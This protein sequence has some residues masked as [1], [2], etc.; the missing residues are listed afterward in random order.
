M[1]RNKQV[2]VRLRNGKITISPNRSEEGSHESQSKSLPT[3]TGKGVNRPLTHWPRC[4]TFPGSVEPGYKLLITPPKSTMRITHTGY[5]GGVF[6]TLRIL[7]CYPVHA[8]PL[9]GGVKIIAGNFSPKPGC[10]ERDAPPP[11]VKKCS[12]ISHFPPT[13]LPNDLPPLGIFIPSP[14]LNAFS[15]RS[16][17]KIASHFPL[18][19]P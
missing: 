5:I 6:D 17:S 12:P 15:Q 9:G 4:Y 1:F 11:S 14:L 18:R 10:C 16:I 19:V 13:F 2:R 8:L 3:R 7:R